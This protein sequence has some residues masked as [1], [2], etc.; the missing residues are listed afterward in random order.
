MHRDRDGYGYTGT[1][2]MNGRNINLTS[3]A[4]LKAGQLL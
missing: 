2:D 4:T 1:L 3:A